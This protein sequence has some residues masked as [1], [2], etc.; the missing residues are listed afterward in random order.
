MCV[1][2]G[3]PPT[4]ERDRARPE[5]EEA[6]GRAAHVHVLYRPFTIGDNYVSTCDLRI[7]LEF[8]AVGVYYVS[9]GAPARL[10]APLRPDSA[11]TT[12]NNVSLVSL[13]K[14]HGLP[15]AIP[16]LVDAL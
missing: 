13:A 5:R 6:I 15:I 10:C 11:L 14:F 3:P 9:P 4:R 8:K 7:C 2:S 1:W 12:D 16:R